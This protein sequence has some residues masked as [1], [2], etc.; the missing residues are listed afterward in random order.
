MVYNWKE[1]VVLITGSGSGIG[2]QLAKLLA[3]KGAYVV[4]NGRNNKR[5]T[6]KENQLLELGYKASSF[7]A[8]ISTVENC[9]ALIQHCQHT[10]GKLDVLINNAALSA[11]GT[12][13]EQISPVVFTQ[14]VQVNFLGA[15]YTT[16][17]ALPLLKQSK[18]SILF[19]SS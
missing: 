19:I 13:V 10:F 5:L 2:W 11:A 4:L 15:V 7:C 9:I 18:G 14:L 8:D 3:G 6:E 17:A 12:T 16:Q 1:K